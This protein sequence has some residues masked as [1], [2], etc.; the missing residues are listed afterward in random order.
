MPIILPSPIEQTWIFVSILLIAV[1]ISLRPKKVA[2]FSFD[3]TKELKGLAVLM[4]I[5]AHVGYI[6]DKNKLFLSPLSDYAS[7]AVNLFLFL[8]GFGLA[9]SALSKKLSVKEFYLRRV[10]K[11][12]LPMWIVII[13]LFLADYFLLQKNYGLKTIIESF[14]GYF[15]V[16]NPDWNLNSPYW[17]I[18]FIVSYYLFFP[19]LFWRKAPAVSAVVIFILSLG[20]LKL[21]LPLGDD[22]HQLMLSHCIAFPL[23]IIA[24][25][26]LGSKKITEKVKNVF[27]STVKSKWLAVTLRTLGILICLYAIYYFY[28]HS[29]WDKGVWIEQIVS[30]T[31]VLLLAI[32][33]SLSPTESRLIGLFGLFSYEIY[34]IHWPLLY[35]YDIFYHFLP[36]SVATIIYLII[37]IGLGYSLRKLDHIVSNHVLPQPKNWLEK[38]WA[39]II[40]IYI[41]IKNR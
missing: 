9:I 32:L 34:L 4:V 23:G 7:V 22:V 19:F 21:N 12:Y 27:Q 24:A 6:L 3:V 25:S 11:V 37:F 20:L 30:N 10:L 29:G 36:A 31:V 1:I 14:L 28:L 13:F 39:E 18:T 2:G 26:I 40:K 8:S 41:K 38:I 16:A 17:Y 5:F 35:R 33:L 15:P